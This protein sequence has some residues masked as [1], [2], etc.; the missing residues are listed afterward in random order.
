M[1]VPPFRSDYRLDRIISHATVIPP[2]A[3]SDA[4]LL[5]YGGYTVRQRV[6]ATDP[7]P[8]VLDWDAKLI[9]NWA[10]A[11]KRDAYERGEPEPR[12]GNVTSGRES[13]GRNRW[14][15]VVLVADCR[16]HAVGDQDPDCGREHVDCRIYIGSTDQQ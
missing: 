6:S 4:A 2:A 8:L 14:R 3:A 1:P 11:H 12:G 5:D 16:N 15:N 7:G 10:S 13:F 9:I